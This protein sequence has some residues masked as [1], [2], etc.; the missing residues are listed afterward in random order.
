MDTCCVVL[1]TTTTIVVHC[2]VICRFVF[3]A[4][5]VQAIDELPQAPSETNHE[6]FHLNDTE[7]Q[8]KKNKSWTKRTHYIVLRTP[9]QK[10]V[11]KKKKKNVFLSATRNR[12]RPIRPQ[13]HETRNTTPWT[14]I[15]HHM[16]LQAKHTHTHTHKS[17][18]PQPSTTHPPLQ[19]AFPY[20]VPKE[21]FLDIIQVLP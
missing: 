18:V 12:P 19:H 2:I 1:A 11:S 8:T 14:N 15:V 9:P 3:S 6:Q 16:V 7:Y 21:S 13:R 4:T 10:K 20:P 17:T 5:L